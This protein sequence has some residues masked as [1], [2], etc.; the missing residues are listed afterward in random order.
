[1]DL[2]KVFLSYFFR[3]ILRH[4]NIFFNSGN[5]SPLLVFFTN[6]HAEMIGV[7]RE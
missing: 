4:L 2:F 5:F 7:Y 1:M 3:Q 6:K